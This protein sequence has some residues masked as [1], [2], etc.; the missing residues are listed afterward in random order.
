MDSIAEVTRLASRPG[1]SS[2]TRCGVESEFDRDPGVSGV[3]ARDEEICA[4]VED[5]WELDWNEDA[6]CV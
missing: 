4:L 6:V 2:A 1:D 5:R 3:E